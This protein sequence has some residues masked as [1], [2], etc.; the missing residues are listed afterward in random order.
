MRNTPRRDQSEKVMMDIDHNNSGLLLTAQSPSYGNMPS[1]PNSASYAAPATPLAAHLLPSSKELRMRG[2]VNRDQDLEDG[3][4][5]SDISGPMSSAHSTSIWP[6][7]SDISHQQRQTPSI[8]NNQQSL[9]ALI[10]REL[11]NILQTPRNQSSPTSFA[12]TPSPLSSIN[13]L[14]T[15]ITSESAQ[16]PNPFS[17]KPPLSL[18][19]PQ[20][21]RDARS[22]LPSSTTPISRRDME[23]L[24]DL[25]A[26]RLIRDRGV[27][28]PTL[29]H[30]SALPP[31]SYS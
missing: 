10:G 17:E 16:T 2:A 5:M 1:T 28:S 11:E 31:P 20:P 15:T 21:H 4:S 26:Q 23:V 9:Q 29:D 8:S 7:N 12:D 3:M 18:I 6:E 27:Q 24:A 14:Q 30:N 19:I 25:V 13:D 22:I